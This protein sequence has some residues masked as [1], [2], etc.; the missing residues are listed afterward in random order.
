MSAG[1]YRADRAGF[2]SATLTPSSRRSIHFFVPFI[3]DQG[4][5]IQELISQLWSEVLSPQLWVASLFSFPSSSIY[6][7]RPLGTNGWQAS[8]GCPF[9]RRISFFCL[10]TYSWNQHVL[11]E[12]CPHMSTF[13]WNHEEW[14]SNAGGYIYASRVVSKLDVSLQ[15]DDHVKEN[16]LY[17]KKRMLNSKAQKINARYTYMSCYLTVSSKLCTCVQ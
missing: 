12:R 7:S 16:R 15:N 1:G 13:T 11:S 6:N 17:R 8:S 5:P 10:S 14:S 3:T 9:D 2:R 4:S